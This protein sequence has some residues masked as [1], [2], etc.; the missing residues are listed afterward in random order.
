MINLMKA[1]INLK[2]IFIAFCFLGVIIIAFS[3]NKKQTPVA[4]V[5]RTIYAGTPLSDK[6]IIESFTNTSK[7]IDNPSKIEEP[8]HSKS[9]LLSLR[10]EITY[11][12][13]TLKEGDLVVA[14][15]FET[16]GQIIANLK[17]DNRL[18]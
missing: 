18:P 1:H 11:F 10:N 15:D 6:I 5:T 14:S 13:K 12:N 8:I 17:S 4:M 3:G 16:N 7:T 2:N 9:A